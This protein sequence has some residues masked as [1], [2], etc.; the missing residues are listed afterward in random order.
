MERDILLIKQAQRILQHPSLLGKLGKSRLLHLRY[1][2]NPSSNPLEHTT[3]NRSDLFQTH[4]MSRVAHSLHKYH[5][6]LQ[7]THNSLN[8]KQPLPHD[9]SI[10]TLLPKTAHR[11]LSPHLIKHNI[12]WLSDISNSQGTHLRRPPQIASGA[13][14]WMTLKH[15]LTSTTNKLIHTTSPRPT[16]FTVTH[17]FK[18]DTIVYRPDENVIT[19]TW[20]NTGK[21]FKV[22]SSYKDPNNGKDICKLQAYIPDNY[23]QTSSSSM[24]TGNQSHVPSMHS[25]ETPPHTDV[26]RKNRTIY[27]NSHTDSYLSGRPPVA[28]PP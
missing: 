26:R 12:T 13:T 27:T 21:Y 5:A 18:P 2:L 6:T 10:I 28:K 15:H 25:A 1:C 20:E 11:S 3:Y 4:W 19:K 17:R 7:D 8:L 24:T 14:W 9:Y 22:I 16:P 23:Y